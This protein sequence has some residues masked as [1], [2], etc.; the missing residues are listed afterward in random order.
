[1]TPGQNLYFGRASA[2]QIPMG[3]VPYDDRVPNAWGRITWDRRLR[4]ENV[5]ERVA[6]WSFTLRPTLAPNEP[7]T[8]A[9]VDVAPGMECSMA[10]PHFEIVAR[11]PGGLGLV[12]SVRIN[13]HQVRHQVLTVT[14]QP[15]VL[16]LN[17]TDAE[18]RIAAELIRPLDAGSAAPATYAEVAAA[19]NYSR[20]GARD[21][22]AR[23]DVKFARAGLYSD[24]T[25]GK[26]PDRVSQTLRKHRGLLA[27][28]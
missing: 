3:R 8:E 19:A 23:I 21:A 27:R 26:T 6:R 1:M 24:I 12:H 10:S 16:E 5:A 2:C 9:E 14:E 20:D 22:I 13:S 15:S 11:A 28:R 18:R 17:L 25:S 4:I 7:Q